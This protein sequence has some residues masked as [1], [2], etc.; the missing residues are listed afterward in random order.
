MLRWVWCCVRTLT[1]SLPPQTVFCMPS[2]N[3]LSIPLHQLLIDVHRQVLAHF[4]R[5]AICVFPLRVQL[6]GHTLLT[7]PF[8]RDCVP[9]VAAPASLG[10]FD[11]VDCVRLG[12]PL[13]H[14]CKRPHSAQELFLT[15]RLKVGCFAWCRR[16]GRYRLANHS[17]GACSLWCEELVLQRLDARLTCRYASVSLHAGIG[18]AR[19]LVGWFG[20]LA[21]CQ[22]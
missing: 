7:A 2:L 1:A 18:A 22:R 12:C 17:D 6:D 4:Y 21:V 10:P 15:V 16:C 11:L 9:C 20:R 5:L 19:A 13:L 14:V 8:A 3:Q